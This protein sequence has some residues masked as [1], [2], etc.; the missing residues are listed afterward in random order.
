M[1]DDITIIVSALIGA[2]GGSLGASFI[3]DFLRRRAER[4]YLHEGLVN[5]YLLQLQDAIESLWYRL[6]NTSGIGGQELMEDSYYEVSTLYALACVFAF[7]RILLLDGV[8]SQLGKQLGRHLKKKMQEFDFQINTLQFLSQ[9]FHYDRLALAE[10]VMEREDGHLR[11]CTFMEFKKHY[12]EDESSVHPLK[13]AKEFVSILRG[14]NV[15]SG[16]MDK[17]VEISILLEK[18]VGIESNI[19]PRH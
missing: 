15:A 5:R 13:S 1:P 19:R 3:N 7:K 16:L 4:T 9:F 2:V 6:D 10:A 11:T 8:Y 18:E 14:S 12:Q 17:L